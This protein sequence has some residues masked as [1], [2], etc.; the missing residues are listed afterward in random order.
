[1]QSHSVLSLGI[2][3]SGYTG[4]VGAARLVLAVRVTVFPDVVVLSDLLNILNPEP[5]G[6]WRLKSGV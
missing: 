4:F 1:M 6:P 5:P 3:I 2:L